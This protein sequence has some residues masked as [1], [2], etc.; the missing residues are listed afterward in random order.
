MKE[1]HETLSRP[2]LASIKGTNNTVD[3]EKF[4]E[5]Y[6]RA[7][8]IGQFAAGKDTTAH[9]LGYPWVVK[10]AS[11]LY[12]LAQRLFPTFQKSDPGGR[13]LLQTL[14]AWGRGE[15]SNEYPLTVERGLASEWV[16][17]QL[18]VDELLLPAI[19]WSAFGTT[20]HFWRDAALDTM[21]GVTLPTA[22]TD[23]RFLNEAEGLWDRFKAPSFLVLCRSE[24]LAERRRALGYEG[25]DAN[26]PSERLAASLVASVKEGSTGHDLMCSFPWFGGVLWADTWGTCPPCA[27]VVHPENVIHFG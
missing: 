16:K 24:T 13:K 18:R 8:F 9:M 15:V 12:M 7:G 14:G 26:D 22:V 10:F 25:R 5:R 2:T 27:A 19:R 6:P 4:L 17:S 1:T 11:P 20:P 3:K 21:E 23:V